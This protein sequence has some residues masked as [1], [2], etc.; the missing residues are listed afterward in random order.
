[1]ARAKLGLCLVGV[2]LAVSVL[3]AQSSKT[4]VEE[5][6]NDFNGK[7]MVVVTKGVSRE[8]GGFYEKCK[9]R[10]LGD[11][12]FLVGQVADVGGAYEQLKGKTV[13][14]KLSEII[15]MTEFDDIE[16]VR[17]INQARRQAEPE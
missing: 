2:V 13:W 4:A 6:E 9:I 16:T 17:K 1:M 7:I 12:H 8:G 11:S 10:K 14:T 15:T 3:L 5:K